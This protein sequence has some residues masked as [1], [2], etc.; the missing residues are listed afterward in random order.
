MFTICIYC[1]FLLSMHKPPTLWRQT[2][3]NAFRHWCWLS[4]PHVLGVGVYPQLHWRSNVVGTLWLAS[5]LGY[6]LLT[7]DAFIVSSCPLLHCPREVLTTLRCSTSCLRTPLHAKVYY[8]RPSKRV[9]RL[10]TLQ[11]PRSYKNIHA[12]VAMP[13]LPTLPASCWKP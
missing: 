7:S 9:C 8:S 1:R 2:H 12:T 4:A 3:S 13:S 6:S 5:R 10:Y 11:W